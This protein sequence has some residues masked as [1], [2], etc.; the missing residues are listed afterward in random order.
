MLAAPHKAAGTADVQGADQ[1]MYVGWGLVGPPAIERIH[2]SQHAAQPFVAGVF[3]YV[4]VGCHQEVVGLDKEPHL[5]ARRSQVEEVYFAGHV[6]HAV[7]IARQVLPFLWKLTGQRLD[8]AV[9][10]L[11]NLIGG[12]VLCE[13]EPV[14]AVI[15]HVT[16]SDSVKNTQPAAYF[17][18]IATRLH[19]PNDVHTRIEALAKTLKTLQ[20][21]PDGSILFEH[22]DG[23]ALLAQHGSC[24]QPAQSCAYDYCMPHPS[25]FLHLTCYIFHLPSTAGIYVRL[26]TVRCRS[27]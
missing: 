23:E 3:G 10:A 22:G 11:A 9:A 1:C 4:V 8:K 6:Q 27:L 7:H 20:A 15:V 13:I 21:A 25:H 18:D 26:S 24:E 12:A 2:I 5:T 17:P 14:G 19:A 16:H